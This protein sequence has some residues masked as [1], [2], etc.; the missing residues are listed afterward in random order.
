MDWDWSTW[1]LVLGGLLCLALLA[2]GVAIPLTIILVL[3]RKRLED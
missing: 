2:A 3:R 1:M